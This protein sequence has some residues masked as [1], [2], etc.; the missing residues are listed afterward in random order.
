V[1]RTTRGEYMG[2]RGGGSRGGQEGSLKQ[3]IE[4]GKGRGGSSEAAKPGTRE[5][6]CFSTR[7]ET[8]QGEGKANTRQAMVPQ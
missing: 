3:E 8:Y 4:K 5:T 1:T 7:G 6:I 2:V